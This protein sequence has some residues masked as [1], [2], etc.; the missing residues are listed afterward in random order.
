V[1]HAPAEAPRRHE[2]GVLRISGEYVVNYDTVIAATGLSGVSSPN[3]E[4]D[5][6]QERHRFRAVGCV[7]EAVK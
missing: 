6:S 2:F 5:W 3:G 7:A 1:I 4:F